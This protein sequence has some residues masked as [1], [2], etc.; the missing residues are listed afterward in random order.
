MK[1][2]FGNKV[3]IVRT[4][5]GLI[6]GA[7]SFRNEYDGHTIDRSL[8]Q[9]RRIYPHPINLLAGDRGYR[10]QSSSGDTKVV[11]PDN[12]QSTDSPYKKRKK[13]ALFRKRAGIEPIIGHLKTDH[14]LSRNFY[15][16]LF[17]DSINV[18]LS[19]AA[20]NFKRAMRA[21]FYIFFKILENIRGAFINDWQPCGRSLPLL[22]P[23]Q[24]ENADNITR[25]WE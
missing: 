18:M 13:H 16:G 21:L 2:E 23:N 20:F 5:S 22:V 15:K 14:R 9:I 17:G 19:A 24:R 25:G 7:L 3:S 12:P 11:I 1:Y 10:G 8:E 6:I 4:Q